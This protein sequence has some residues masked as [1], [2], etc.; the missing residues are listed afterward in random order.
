MLVN[1]W[2]DSRLAFL[3]NREL[4]GI[5]IESSFPGLSLTMCSAYEMQ[6]FLIAPADGGSS[7]GKQNR[8]VPWCVC[9]HTRQTAL[10]LTADS[11]VTAMCAAQ[12]F[13]FS[14]A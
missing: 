7:A 8:F 1:H 6:H 12:A 2:Y 10:V 4:I 13:G 3:C 11:A 9:L 5:S 14:F